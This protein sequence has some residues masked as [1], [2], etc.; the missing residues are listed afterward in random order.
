MVFCKSFLSNSTFYFQYEKDC[1]KIK[2]K[3]SNE[4]IT[5]NSVTEH[6]AIASVK[7]L[8]AK[9][10]YSEY[11]TGVLS[12]QFVSFLVSVFSVNSGY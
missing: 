1:W 9:E 2:N 3:F 6:D 8:P 7:T 12:K 4:R 11:Y 5:L 10:S